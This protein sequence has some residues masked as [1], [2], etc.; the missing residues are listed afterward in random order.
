MF[1]SMFPVSFDP[2]SSH[3]RAIYVVVVLQMPLP[4]GYISGIIHG[5][6]EA[7]YIIRKF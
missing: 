7:V 2:S 1:N 6:L 5:E 4:P 3:K